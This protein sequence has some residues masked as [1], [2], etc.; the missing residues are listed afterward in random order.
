MLFLILYLSLDFIWYFFNL[1][2]P[3]LLT[4]IVKK[5]FDLYG[6]PILFLSS[7]LEGMLL[8]GGYFPGVFVIFLAIILSDSGPEAV[9]A[10]AVASLGL[11]L[12]HIGNYLLGKYGW[13]RLLTKLGLKS[14]HERA[15]ER[16][17]KRG[18]IAIFLSYWLPSIGALTDTA[19]GIIQMRFKTFIFYSL[20]STIFW[21]SIVGVTVYLT[22]QKAITVAVGGTSSIIVYSIVTIWIII[23]LVLDH[24]EKNNSARPH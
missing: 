3:E 8:I 7:I 13:Y 11:I 9:V 6:L 21:N 2:S 24:F 10:V 5:W 14:A 23:V 22:G 19:A 15:K 17:E 12:A 18:P 20:I 16:L 4:Q 1:P